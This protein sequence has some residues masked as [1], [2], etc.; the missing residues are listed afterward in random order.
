MTHRNQMNRTASVVGILTAILVLTCASNAGLAAEGPVAGPAAPAVPPK[1]HAPNELTFAFVKVVAF[2]DGNCLIIKHGS[3]TSNAAGEAFT[4]EV[5]DTAVLGTFWAVPKDGRLLSMSAGI[6]TATEKTAKSAPCTTNLEILLANKGKDCTVVMDDKN[7]F[8]G[9]IRDVL[10]I[11]SEQPV[12]DA[13]A[14]AVA[15]ARLARLRMSGAVSDW[16]GGAFDST[17]TPVPVSTTV[18]TPA[19][20]LFVLHT[21]TGD[22]LLNVDQVR[23]LTIAAMTLASDR[24][25]TKTKNTKRL[26]F[27][28]DKPNAAQEIDLMYFTPGLRWIPTYRMEIAAET[29]PKKEARISLQA[30]L[31]NDIEDL[32]AVPID[33]VVGV[34]NFRFKESVSPLSLEAVLRGVLPQAQQDLMQQ[35]QQLSNAYFSNRND[36]GARGD[37]PALAG[38]AATLQAELTAGGSQDLFVYSLPKMT[39]KKGHRA[40]VP[41]FDATAP[42]RDVYTWEATALRSDADTPDANNWQRSPLVISKNQVWHQVELTNNTSVPWT[43][44]PVMIMQG[45]QPVAQELLTYTA[46]KSFARVPL[47]VAVDAQSTYAEKETGRQANAIEWFGNRYMRVDKEGTLKIV[48]HKTIPIEVVITAQIG[49][50]ADSA[51]DAG[52]PTIGDFRAEDW[53]NYTGHPALNNHSSVE[54]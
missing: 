11:D 43:T 45:R 44:G 34:P 10:T 6:V 12:P 17:L 51:S 48:N 38:G 4:D 36:A 41:I 5:P 18:T 2:K 22:V 33:L 50:T 25:E 8:T 28:F 31:I 19:G 7:T 32:D 40:A 14:P 35:G 21:A 54:W 39:L 46:V 49:G 1:P 3:A 13:E 42:Y 27:R 52:K 16:A 53:R 9:S 30:E 23:S 26:T 24:T 37:G 15:T 20:R 29:D 47:T